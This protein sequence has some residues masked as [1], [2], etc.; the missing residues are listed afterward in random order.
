MS[1][2]HVLDSITLCRGNDE[3]C[4]GVW[5]LIFNL[6]FQIWLLTYVDRDSPEGTYWLGKSAKAC[7]IIIEMTMA[8]NLWLFRDSLKCVQG[9]W[10]SHAVRR[11][12]APAPAPAPALPAGRITA[13]QAVDVWKRHFEERGVTEPDNSSHYIIAH[14]LGAKTVSWHLLSLF[15]IDRSECL[16]QHLL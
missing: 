16:S 8:V 6:S 2:N 4:V 10:G 1:R 12:S 11:C 15:Y 5:G 14:L 3:N 13:R 7:E 9:I